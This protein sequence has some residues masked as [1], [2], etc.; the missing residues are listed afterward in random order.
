LLPPPSSPVDKPVYHKSS[1][2]DSLRPQWYRR[3]KSTK[4]DE[5]I[6]FLKYAF[7]PQAARSFEA[8]GI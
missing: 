6:T 8:A 4:S 3:E 5:S 1:T 7:G 2:L